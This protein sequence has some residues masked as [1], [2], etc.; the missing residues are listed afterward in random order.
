MTRSTKYSGSKNTFPSDGEV[1]A[2]KI[3]RTWI[4]RRPEYGG[5]FRQEGL[6]RG[7][8]DS[9]APSRSRKGL[10]GHVQA[11]GHYLRATEM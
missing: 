7:I 10:E 2:R 3:N 4:A 1:G 9:A 6:E 8:E 5:Y 11:F